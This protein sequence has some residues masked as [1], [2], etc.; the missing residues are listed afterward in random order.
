M[1]R[2]LPCWKSK[3]KFG[4]KRGGFTEAA[5]PSLLKGCGWSEDGDDDDGD[6]RMRTQH[7]I[8][9]QIVVMSLPHNN[10]VSSCTRIGDGTIDEL[11]MPEPLLR[12]HWIPDGGGYLDRDG[13]GMQRGET[14]H[15]GSDD[16]F[17]CK[18]DDRSGAEESS[19]GAHWRS[20]NR[21]PLQ[22]QSSSTVY[23]GGCVVRSAEAGATTRN[24]STTSA[25]ET[26]G[27]IER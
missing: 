26:A 18:Q 15:I 23:R 3:A 9:S 13:G 19:D 2:T 11:A 14:D 4:R 17:H 21:Q 25:T 24:V 10:G 12:N 7:P 20:R 22:P 8:S 1:S 6:S 27:R 5:A 16:G